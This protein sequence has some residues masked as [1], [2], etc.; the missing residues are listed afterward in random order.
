MK[1]QQNPAPPKTGTIDLT[2]VRLV[3]NGNASFETEMLLSLQLEIEQKMEAIAHDL[4]EGRREGVRLCAHRL[5]NL[6]GLLGSSPLR[7]AFLVLETECMSVN[8]D[9]LIKQY[10]SCNEAWTRVQQEVTLLLAASREKAAA[11]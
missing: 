2:Y 1:N 9:W 3:S 6:F 4:E 11:A 10:R 5:K 8:N 7:D